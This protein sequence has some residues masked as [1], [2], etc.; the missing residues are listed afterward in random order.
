MFEPT[1]E[2]RLSAQL[3]VNSLQGSF[4]A[5]IDPLSEVSLRTRSDVG[6]IFAVELRLILL[7]LPNVLGRP[8]SVHTR[9]MKPPKAAESM[10]CQFTTTE[11]MSH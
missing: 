1:R 7:L 4:Q 11:P 8:T 2:Q 6:H 5:L 10:S 9:A 3:V